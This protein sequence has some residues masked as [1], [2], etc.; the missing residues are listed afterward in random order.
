MKEYP[1]DELHSVRHFSE[2]TTSHQQ[3]EDDLCIS[4]FLK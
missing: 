2:A 4:I 1:A 3:T